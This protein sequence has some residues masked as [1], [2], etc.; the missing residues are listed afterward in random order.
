MYIEG[1]HGKKST[2][3]TSSSKTKGKQ[4][5]E[6][7]GKQQKSKKFANATQTKDLHCNHCKKMVMTKIIDGH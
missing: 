7:K 1:K 2:N 5:Q 3:G 6:G 4:T